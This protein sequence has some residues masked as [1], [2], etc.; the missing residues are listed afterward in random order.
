MSDDASPAASYAAAT[1]D[2]RAAARWL[3]TA[4][5]VAGAA[6]AAGLQLTSIGSLGLSDWPRLLAAGAGLAAALGTVG[7][8]IFR[9]SRLLTNEWITLAQLELEQFKRQLRDSGRRRD[10]RRAALIDRIYK[11][12]HDNQDELYGGVANS[13]S[14]L[15]RQL[16]EANAAARAFPRRSRVQKAADLRNAAETLVQ[17]ANYSYIR[18]DFT[19]LRRDLAWAGTVFIAGVVIFA[20][21]ANPPK[22]AESAR[23][24]GPTPSHLTASASAV[25]GHSRS[26]SPGSQAGLKK[27]WPDEP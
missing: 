27:P 6:I 11:E 25:P 4:A 13:V 20:C 15:Y 14:D 19:A 9:T 18:A 3:L 8:M 16:I 5:A 7:Y 2:L 12:L 26:R 23:A 24:A 1:S 10:K 17:A 22:T 21:A